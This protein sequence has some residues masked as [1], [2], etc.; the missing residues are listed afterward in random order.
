MKKGENNDGDHCVEKEEMQT[1]EQR[2]KKKKPFDFRNTNIRN[3]HVFTDSHAHIDTGT[4]FG[5]HIQSN[6]KWN[7]GKNCVG[8][9]IEK[10][11]FSYTHTVFTFAHCLYEAVSCVN[12]LNAVIHFFYSL[13]SED[14]S[15]S[16]KFCH[17]SIA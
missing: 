15:G 14:G 10:I 13:K 9:S 8:K 6:Q 17:F 5:A 4:R 12:L 3:A 7:R 1:K 11:R 2:A 16:H